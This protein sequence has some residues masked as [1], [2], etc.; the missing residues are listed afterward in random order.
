[1]PLLAKHLGVSRAQVYSR[2][3]TVSDV[4]RRILVRDFIRFVDSLPRECRAPGPAGILATAAA[5]IRFGREHSIITKVIVDEPAMIAEMLPH[6]D[7]LLATGRR[8][9][10][11]YLKTGMAGGTIRPGDP[12]ATADLIS[13]VV[14]TSVLVAPPGD[15]KLYLRTVLGPVLFP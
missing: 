6:L 8:P 7:V 15:L 13:R 4:A 3:G 1:V 11:Q 14:L 10:A 9:L 12:E 2:F 5:A